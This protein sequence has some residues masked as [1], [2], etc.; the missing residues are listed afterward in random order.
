MIYEKSRMNARAIYPLVGLML[1]IILGL[2]YVV[3]KSMQPSEAIINSAD[4]EPAINTMKN[5]KMMS[6]D[7]GGKERFSDNENAIVH[8][9]IVAVLPLLPFILMV[10][11]ITVVILNL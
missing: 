9:F 3:R 7:L 11:I 4:D 5:A 6:F 2:G 1:I 8:K 10:F